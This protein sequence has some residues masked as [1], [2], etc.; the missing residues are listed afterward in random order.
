M[1]P[2]A[3][4]LSLGTSAHPLV[5]VKQPMMVRALPMMALAVPLP[6]AG[7]GRGFPNPNPHFVQTHLDGSVPCFQA[8]SRPKLYLAYSMGTLVT[9]PGL[10]LCFLCEDSQHQKR[11]LRVVL[12]GV[13]DNTLGTFLWYFSKV[14]VLAQ[15]Q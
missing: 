6:E 8:V 2:T 15:R 3:L 12:A 5:V 9:E 13:F 14:M 4:R 11:V 1:F 7:L 10:E